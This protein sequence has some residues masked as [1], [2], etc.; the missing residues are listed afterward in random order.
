M[1][2]KVLNLVAREVRAG[3]KMGKIHHA[4]YE[5]LEELIKYY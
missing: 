1:K 3:V 2:K 4:L 5:S